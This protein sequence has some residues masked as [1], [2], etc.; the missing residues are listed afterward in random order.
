MAGL[1]TDQRLDIQ[2]VDL[3]GVLDDG[4]DKRT[5]KFMLVEHN[6]LSILALGH[7]ENY[8]YHAQI[9][10]ALCDQRE[11]AASWIRRRELLRIFDPDVSIAGGG[12]FD[13]D[14]LEK[15]LR[16]YGYSTAYG[17]YDSG[18]L[19]SII[20]RSDRLQTFEIFES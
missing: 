15:S 18:L 4:S 13:F 2:V 19:G 3:S 11:I 12:W 9:L 7:I 1:S 14:P 16:F 10:A 5:G 17:Q 6:G 8:K 20:S